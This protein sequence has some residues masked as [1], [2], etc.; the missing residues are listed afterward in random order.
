VGE[1]KNTMVASS[2][3]ELDQLLADFEQQARTRVLAIHSDYAALLLR[4]QMTGFSVDEAATSQQMAAAAQDWG[5]LAGEGRALLARMK[6]AM[7]EV[8]AVIIGAGLK[9]SNE[10][11][12]KSYLRAKLSCDADYRPLEDASSRLERLI[13][14]AERAAST[15]RLMVNIRLAAGRSETAL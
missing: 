5:D 13:G 9:G 11:A 7:E 1:D 6:V 10:L 14:L 2:D 8:E 12:R 3:D 4:G 15:A